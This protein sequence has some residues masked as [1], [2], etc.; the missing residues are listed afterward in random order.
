[1]VPPVAL[2][3]PLTPLWIPGLVCADLAS[4]GG[5]EDESQGE[6]DTTVTVTVLE[7]VGHKPGQG[8]REERRLLVHPAITICEFW[9]FHLR[10]SYSSVQ[11]NK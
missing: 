7:G 3:A 8:M 4:P 9:L 10:G 5:E 1:M 11:L 6:G 2:V